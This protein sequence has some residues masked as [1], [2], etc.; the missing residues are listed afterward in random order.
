MF[1]YKHRI[2]FRNQEVINLFGEEYYCD[3][4]T[5]W[6]WHQ[7]QLNYLYNYVLTTEFPFKIIDLENDIT[8]IIK[9]Q[10]EFDYWISKNQPFK[11]P[12]L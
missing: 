7:T 1:D 4:S 6:N 9:N 2:E 11:I 10:K 3:K 8:L 12:E 5:F